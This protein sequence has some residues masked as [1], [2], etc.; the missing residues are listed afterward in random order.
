MGHKYYDPN[1]NRG[2]FCDADVVNFFQEVSLAVDHGAGAIVSMEE[3]I[4]SSVSF[5]FIVICMYT[6][7]N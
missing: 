4:V 7:T 5:H 1:Q 2:L 6:L 3:P